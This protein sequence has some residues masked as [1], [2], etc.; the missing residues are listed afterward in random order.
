M[1]NRENNNNMYAMTYIKKPLNLELSFDTC[2]LYFQMHITHKKENIRKLE[3]NTTI[4]QIMK[5]DIAHDDDHNYN[6]I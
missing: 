5:F 3:L 1:S 2:P 4:I 6:N